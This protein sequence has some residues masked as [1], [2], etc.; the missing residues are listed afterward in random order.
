MNAKQVFKNK[1]GTFLTVDHVIEIVS[2]LYSKKLAKVW[3]IGMGWP[4][5]YNYCMDSDYLELTGAPSLLKNNFRA[6]WF[7]CEFLD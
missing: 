1:P 5:G 6:V 4:E 7:A 3:F 2:N